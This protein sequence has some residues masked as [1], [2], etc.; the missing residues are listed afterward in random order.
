VIDSPA[1]DVVVFDLGGVLIDWD[2][3]HLY[4]RLFDDEADKEEYLATVCTPAWHLRHD[5]GPGL[6]E[7]C[8][9]LAA[10]HP[11]QAA[12]IMAWAERS[13]EMVKGAIEGTVEILSELKAAGVPCYG[14][15]NMEPETFPLRVER[16][17]FL[18]WFDGMVVSGFEGVAKPDPA[19]FRLLLDRYGLAADRALFVDDLAGNVAAARSVG[20]HGLV[21]AS[22][23]GLRAVLEDE[24]LLVTRARRSCIT[25]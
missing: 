23:A 1:I 6:V 22:P 21:F 9:A 15:T 12:L 24:G 2:P 16:F 25:P 10:A 5:L 7:S 18:S 3:R 4:R 20:L 19:I 17:D 11:A 8:E 13:E 14:L